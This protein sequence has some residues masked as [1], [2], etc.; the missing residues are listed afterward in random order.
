MLDK[1]KAS[2][3][4]AIPIKISKENLDIFADILCTNINSSFKSSSFPF[5]LKM[6]NVTP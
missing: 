2:R 4:S 1:N 3:H 6:A 5:C